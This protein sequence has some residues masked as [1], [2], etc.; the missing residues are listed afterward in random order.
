MAVLQEHL[1][2]AQAIHDRNRAQED[3]ISTRDA[4]DRAERLATPDE[5]AALLTRAELSG[6]EPLARAV[7]AHAFTQYTSGS[8]LGAQQ[9]EW[10]G[11]VNAY[12]ARRPGE[13]EAVSELAA[14]A[15]AST[16]PQAFAES[17]Y[18]YVPVPHELDGI[19]AGQLESLAGNAPE[20]A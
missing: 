7:A 11:V 2:A 8:S 15:Q 13:S 9:A 14:I 5:A 17:M 6:D 16:V 20:A 1:D 3:R 19:S 18:F 12:S 4:A 10:A